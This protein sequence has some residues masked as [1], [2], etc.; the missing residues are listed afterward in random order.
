MRETL[1]VDR[2]C[3]AVSVIGKCTKAFCV[4]SKV[5]HNI[6]TPKHRASGPESAASQS[7]RALAPFGFLALIR[8]FQ[9]ARVRIEESVETEC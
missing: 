7:H 5:C 9:M 2:L 8:M 1:K 3:M 4:K 6:T